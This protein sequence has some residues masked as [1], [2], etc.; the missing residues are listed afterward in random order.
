[1]VVIGKIL[2]KI[3]AGIVISLQNI[4]FTSTVN[5][6][7]SILA[8]NQATDHGNLRRPLKYSSKDIPRDRR[9]S[10]CGIAQLP[11]SNQLE[12]LKLLFSK[13]KDIERNQL[14]GFCHHKELDGIPENELTIN[15][16]VIGRCI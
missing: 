4:F 16:H 1:M 5:N 13:L 6:Y 12:E 15:Q 9:A 14:Q 3:S 11:S 8:E 10:F 7:L 2:S